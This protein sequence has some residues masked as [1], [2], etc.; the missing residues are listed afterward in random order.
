MISDDAASQ[1]GT[2]PDTAARVAA[3]YLAGYDCGEATGRSTGH[4]SGYIEGYDAGYLDGY[5]AALAD[6]ERERAECL[7]E[8]NRQLVAWLASRPSYAELCDLRGDRERADAQRELLAERGVA[9]APAGEPP[10]PPAARRSSPKTR[11]R[12]VRNAR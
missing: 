12:V 8:A 6:V 9:W 5:G 7:G 3:G 11:P 10:T 2:P 1:Q 4:R